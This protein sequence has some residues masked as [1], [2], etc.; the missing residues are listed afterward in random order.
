L[1]RTY[2]FNGR[3]AVESQYSWSN[4]EVVLLDYYKDILK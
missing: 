4:Q 2:A 1:A 3:I